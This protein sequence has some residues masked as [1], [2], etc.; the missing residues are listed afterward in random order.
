M[1]D[2]FDV[3]EKCSQANSSE[4]SA[5]SFS[6]MLE[7]NNLYRGIYGLIL[8]DIPDVQIVDP[9]E[10]TAHL[11]KENRMLYQWLKEVDDTKGP[12]HFTVKKMVKSGY[13]VDE[14]FFVLVA[15][16][17]EKHITVILGMDSF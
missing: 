9:S 2:N 6:S 15:K 4:K 7:N 16:H 12:V 14:L 3:K 8:T 1:N 5:L 10:I 13:Q 17:F 11:I